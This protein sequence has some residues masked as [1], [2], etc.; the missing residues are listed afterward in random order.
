MGENKE[1]SITCY[2][3][4]YVHTLDKRPS[5]FMRDKPIFSSKRMLHKD[6]DSKGSVEKKISCCESQG[7]W[8]R[9][10]LIDGKSAVIK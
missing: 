3:N 4:M 8:R 6:Y 7:A 9:D 5:I 1:F 10:E 2:M